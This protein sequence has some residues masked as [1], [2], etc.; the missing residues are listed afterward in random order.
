MTDKGKKYF[1]GWLP[2][3]NSVCMSMMIIGWLP[4]RE[5]YK[6][7]SEPPNY[8]IKVMQPLRVIELA[9]VQPVMQNGVQSIALETQYKA[10]EL[11][12]FNLTDGSQP[13]F[14]PFYRKD[15]MTHQLVDENH[16]AAMFYEKAIIP[17]RTNQIGLIPASPGNVQELGKKQ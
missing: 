15:F 1:I 2:F 10:T 5:D 11:P 3:G 14:Y 16:A 8:M 4:D 9:I 7:L 6:L 12:Y 13:T 17:I